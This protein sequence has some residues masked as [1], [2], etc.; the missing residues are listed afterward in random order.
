MSAEGRRAGV[1][2]APRRRSADDQPSAA[3]DV[4]GGVRDVVARLLGGGAC[5]V[6]LTAS[7]EV[8]VAGDLAGGFLR[9][10]GDILGGVLDLVSH[11]HGGP[12]RSL[13]SATA[14]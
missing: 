2:G 6:S 9:L 14:G 5:L 10:A 13:L 12:L 8:L 7:F 4:L 3:E 1:P 11:S